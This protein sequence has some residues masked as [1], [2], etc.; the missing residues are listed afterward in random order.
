VGQVKRPPIP[1]EEPEDDPREAEGP[2]TVRPPPPGPAEASGKGIPSVATYQKLRESCRAQPVGDE[3]QLDDE[4]AI[5]AE[6][7]RVAMDRKRG[8]PGAPF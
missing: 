5:E 2:I 8:K 4:L 1:R 3:S 6:I 7:L